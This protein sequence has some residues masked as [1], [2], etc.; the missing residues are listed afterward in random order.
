MFAV[1]YIVASFSPFWNDVLKTL[2]TSKSNPLGSMVE[3]VSETTIFFLY[4]VMFDAGLLRFAEQIN[5]T[6]VDSITSTLAY[7]DKITSETGTIKKKKETNT[8]VTSAYWLKL[9]SE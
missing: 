2:S 9:S 3:D 1:Q 4:Q 8:C 5:V 7:G 6:S